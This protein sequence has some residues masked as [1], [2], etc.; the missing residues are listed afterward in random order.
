MHFEHAWGWGMGAV[1]ERG[2]EALGEK[3][4]SS[5]E[6]VQGLQSQFL[7]DKNWSQAK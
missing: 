7:G 5:Q 4:L 3:V 2:P 1:G 6:V